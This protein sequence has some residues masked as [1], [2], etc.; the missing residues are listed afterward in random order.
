[1]KRSDIHYSIYLLGLLVLVI[2]LP[3]SHFVM[4]LATF[5]LFLNWVAEWNWKEKWQRIKNQKVGLVFAALYLFLFIGLIH[6]DNWAAARHELLAQLPLVFMPVLLTTSRPVTPK[7]MKIITHGFVLSTL[8][9]CLCSW[10]Y[11][12]SRSVT[13][14]RDISLFVD[15]IR[16][17][18]CVVLSF[19]FTVSLM[20][21][22]EVTSMSR[23]L[24]GLMAVML[25][26]YAIFSH[27][28]T[29][30]VCLFVI[31]TIYA[32]WQL[33]TAPKNQKKQSVAILL[34]LLLFSTY[35]VWISVQFFTNK[36]RYITQ[37]E[38]S[39]GNPYTF[40]A[41]TPIENG[42]RVGYYICHEELQKAWA[43]RSDSAMTEG[44]ENVIIRYLNSKGLHKDYDALM[45]LD[46][47]DIRNIEKGIPNYLYPRNID[48]RSLLYPTYFSISLYQCC[49]YIENSSLLERLELWKA[50]WAQFKQHPL[51]GVGLGDHKDMVDAQLEAQ[52]SSIA[53]KKQRGSH[54]QLLTFGLMSG[55]LMVL[56]FLFMILYPFVRMRQQISFVYFAFVLLMLMSMVIEDTLES[57]TG[58]LLFSVMMPLLLLYWPSMTK[59]T[60]G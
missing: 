12:I 11:W 51:L 43:L 2:S 57:Q 13:E 50:S 28:L 26:A 54:N 34:L 30:I 47:K 14:M 38:T 53:H 1:M 19:I 24:Y 10:I 20:V 25:F 41:N 22:C 27:T 9:C 29:G 40:D 23:M 6:T 8:F 58:R 5:V 21:H 32:L 42:H 4:G 55:V 48:F 52:H 33:V 59:P 15:H 56:Y 18:L 3:L 44:R 31:I 16:F 49:N 37:M 35:L 60:E 7:A 45:S 39:A 46:H 36:D 17:S